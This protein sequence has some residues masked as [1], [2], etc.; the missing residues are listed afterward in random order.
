MSPTDP[1]PDRTWTITEL[2]EEYAVTL[3]TLRHYEEVGLLFPERRG[4]ARVFHQR[5]RIRLELILRGKRLGF[6]LPQIATIVNMYDEQPG[7]QGQL[8]YLLE[9]IEV[10]RAEL[11]QRRRDIEDTLAELDRVEHRCREDLTRL[12]ARPAARHPASPGPRRREALDSGC[13]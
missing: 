4:T 8:E 9:Q 11:A 7:E 3:R 13:S 2:G 1:E 12:A 6:T 5:D 10:R